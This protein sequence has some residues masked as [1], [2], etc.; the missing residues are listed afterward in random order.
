MMPIELIG[1][2]VGI[3]WDGSVGTVCLDMTALRWYRISQKRVVT[4]LDMSI[5][6][7]HDP[8]SGPTGIY[9]VKWVFCLANAGKQT[10]TMKHMG[11][12]FV[13]QVLGRQSGSM[14]LLVMK[15]AEDV[16]IDHDAL[17]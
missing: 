17:A 8:F 4:P 2:F 5:T 15:S 9:L 13:Q 7:C 1:D 11:W 14:D 10:S 16:Q 6:T 12:I 3:N